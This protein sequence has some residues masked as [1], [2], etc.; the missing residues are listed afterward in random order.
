MRISPLYY[1]FLHHQH[2]ILLPSLHHIKRWY[3]FSATFF[4]LLSLW[5]MSSLLSNA[6]IMSRV[7]VLSR[8]HSL[9]QL[10]QWEL[11]TA[12]I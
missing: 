11:A 1:T 4:V 3:F 7:A 5:V 9:G 8:N 10:L 2:N 6:C 12:E